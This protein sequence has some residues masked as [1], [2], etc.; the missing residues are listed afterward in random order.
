MDLTDGEAPEGT[1]D[2]AERDVSTRAGT[3]PGIRPGWGLMA[4]A[5]VSTLVVN[6]NTSA[7]SILLPSISV[8]LQTPVAVLQ[9]AVTG[10]LLVGAAVIVTSGAMGDVFGR[11]RVFVAG[12]ALFVVSCV[13]IALAQ[14]GTMVVLGRLVQ[15][16]AGA[17]ILACGLSLLSVASA[18]PAQM[19]AVSLWGAAA[20]AGAAG[21]PVLGGV[22][23][24]AT[25]WQG[26][27]WIDA[28]IAAVCIP[29]ALRT[30]AESRDENRPRTIDFAGTALIAGI[31]VPFVFA[32]TEGSTWGWFSVPTLACLVLTLAATVG[33]VAVER[34]VSSPLVDLRLLRNT[35]LVVSTWVIF[36]G[37]GAIAALSFILS[38][39]F[40][41]P[42]TLGFS[43]LIAGLAMLP[44]AAVVI[45]LAPLV[46]PLARHFGVRSVVL[47]GFVVLTAGFFLL[48]RA[49][50]SWEYGRFLFPLL[51]IAAGLSLTNGPAS[52]IST[53]C[54]TR[55]QVGQASGISNMARYVGGAVMTAVVAGIYSNAI[56]ARTAEGAPH[57]DALASGFAEGCIALAIFSA[58]T[59]VFAV[60]SARR[61][62]RPH[63]IDAA[64][65]A[66]STSHTLPVA[67][68]GRDH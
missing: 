57:A 24:E 8:D 27:F 43:S 36:V 56:A 40:Q 41:D 59:I 50:P 11:R 51:C 33:F 5:C 62:G 38:L 20:A 48:A 14:T 30:V 42:G 37:A 21:G 23:N 15:G 10:Y 34:R 61:P 44:L 53:S 22:L 1:G 35:Q 54:V 46:T 26:R 64:A 4:V 13:L 29:L 9:W 19:R 63:A 25:G 52:S 3:D 39:Y 7:V 2:D 28:V 16:A 58:S 47:A 32:M 60:V 17:T 55:E 67:E 31:L 18:G 6:A 68:I 45:I 49:D 12:L 66:A 65:A